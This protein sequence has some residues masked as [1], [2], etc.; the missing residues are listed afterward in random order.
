MIEAI[1]R[2]LRGDYNSIRYRYFH[3]PREWMTYILKYRL[4][5]KSWVDFYGARLDGFKTDGEFGPLKPAYAKDGEVHF[6]YL[7]SHGL[8]PSHSLLDYGCGVMRSGL[9][10]AKYLDPGNYVGV[11]ISEQRL[12]H[13]RHLMSEAGISECDY[14]A[15]LVH[16]CRLTEL[17][18]RSFD[19]VWANS[20]LTHM[21]ESDIR[22][23]LAALS[24]L[25]AEDGKFYF[26]FADADKRRR[27]HI[28]DFWYPEAEM[29]S[30]FNSA[31][32]EC[33]V[34]DHYAED[35]GDVMACATLRD[36]EN[37]RR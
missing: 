16:D 2:H 33:Q 11:D 19:F 29:R 28:K 26:T 31:G 32:Y 14:G 10:F 4:F 34:S 17:K 7:L 8:K 21:P 27:K 36:R 1:K 5:G 9:F 25:L 23:M 13:G 24:E 20:V 15:I 30:I 18:G 12:A 22:T 35:Y 37:G 3:L 6:N